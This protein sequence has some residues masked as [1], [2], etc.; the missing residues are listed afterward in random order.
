MKFGTDID[1]DECG[2]WFSKIISKSLSTVFTFKLC[3]L[4]EFDDYITLHNL[5]MLL[6]FIRVQDWINILII[7]DYIH[8]IRITV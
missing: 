8:I 1:T 5:S 6:T 4:K 3:H 2:K 7:H